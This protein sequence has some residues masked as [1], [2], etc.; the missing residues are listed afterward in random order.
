MLISSS[1]ATSPIQA[2]KPS[3]TKPQYVVGEAP[4]SQGDK[5]TLSKAALDLAAQEKDIEFSN[6]VVMQMASQNDQKAEDM[7]AAFT[8]GLNNPLIDISNLNMATGE[9]ATYSATGQPVTDASE[10]LFAS[11][12]E[13]LLKRNEILIAQE[14][15]K[16]TPAAKILEKVM[17][18]ID[19]Q[20]QSYKDKIDWSRLS[21]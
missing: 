8:Y 1:Y 2:Y 6:S 14:R 7:L 13:S 12:N 4:A 21:S 18:S 20:P 16:G 9:G 15:E 11:Q 17:Q 19:Q 3:E 5:V 10:A